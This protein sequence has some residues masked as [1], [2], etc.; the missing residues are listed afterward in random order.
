MLSGI[1]RVL[2]HI[3]HQALLEITQGSIHIYRDAAVGNMNLLIEVMIP[4]LVERLHHHPHV[5]E[6]C[7]S[8]R[9]DDLKD[10]HSEGSGFRGIFVE[11]LNG[12]GSY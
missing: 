4:D 9:P 11:P 2:I 1:G 3:H 7:T 10:D 12:C 8:S 5:G 6:T